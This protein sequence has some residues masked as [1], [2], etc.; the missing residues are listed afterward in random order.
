MHSL[1]QVRKICE[2][3]HE[4]FVD[5]IINATNDFCVTERATKKELKHRQRLFAV[6]NLHGAFFRNENKYHFLFVFFLL[7]VSECTGLL[8]LLIEMLNA[9]YVKQHFCR[10]VIRIFRH[11]N[12][13]QT[14]SRGWIFN[15]SQ[16][17]VHIITK[18]ICVSWF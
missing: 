5:E 1:Y 2:H 17:F 11:F 6:V 8:A 15:G 9:V 10:T 14:I 3:H 13:I 4:I 18:I 12:L 16:T 7:H